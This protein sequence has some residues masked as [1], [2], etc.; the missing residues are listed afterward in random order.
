MKYLVSLKVNY[1]YLKRSFVIWAVMFKPDDAVNEDK[2]GHRCNRRE[3]DG[4]RLGQ[5]RLEQVVENVGTVWK[6]F[7]HG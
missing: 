7:V 2:P 5:P 1:V 4:Q 3:R 6:G